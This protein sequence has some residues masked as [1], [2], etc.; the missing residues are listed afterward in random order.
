MQRAMAAE[1]EA[2]REARAKVIAAEGEQNASR[3]LKEAADIISS[4]PA[5]LQVFSIDRPIANCYGFFTN[6]FWCL[7]CFVAPL[8]ANSQHHIGRE[9]LHHH[10]PSSH[11]NYEPF[12][13]IKEFVEFPRVMGFSYRTTKSVILNNTIQL[14]WRNITILVALYRDNTSIPLIFCCSTMVKDELFE[15]GDRQQFLL[16]Q[17][18]QCLIAY[19]MADGISYNQPRSQ[20]QCRTWMTLVRCHNDA[21][22]ITL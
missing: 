4:S 21:G 3:A 9:E 12:H 8:S 5:A 14:N 1:A 19:L 7:L 13:K 22:F 17:A 11:G 6:I 18:Y 20:N 15:R 10:F 2:S 16:A